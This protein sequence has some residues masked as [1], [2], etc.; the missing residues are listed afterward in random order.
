M[1]TNATEKTPLCL[2]SQDSTFQDKITNQYNE[3]K[4][5]EIESLLSEEQA[6][7]KVTDSVS[8][9]STFLNFKN[10]LPYQIYFIAS[11]AFF[12]SVIF[13]FVGINK[14][15]N[16]KEINVPTVSSAWNSK[17]EPFSQTNPVDIGIQN[18]LRPSFSTPG[19]VFKEMVEKNHALPTNSWFE[20][21]L[22]G[23]FNNLPE[24]NVFQV[25]YILDLAGP[26]VGIR[27]HPCHLEAYSKAVMVNR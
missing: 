2:K 13:L 8:F 20:N 18:V 10:G 3:T 22:L 11:L 6:K 27:S 7:E 12:F 1:N 21:F 23:V 19:I 16:L 17:A 4:Q 26:I 15:Q 5:F 24:N 14:F 25:P 9:A